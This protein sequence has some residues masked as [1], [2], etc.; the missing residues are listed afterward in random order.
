ML[1]FAIVVVAATVA[2]PAAGIADDQNQEHRI[3]EKNTIIYWANAIARNRK[4][5]GK[6]PL[7]NVGR[8]QKKRLNSALDQTLKGEGHPEEFCKKVKEILQE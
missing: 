5:G 2:A 8:A 6:T 7:P 3:M 4:S 1:L